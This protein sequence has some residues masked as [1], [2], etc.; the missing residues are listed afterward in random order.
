MSGLES[1]GDKNVESDLDLLGEYKE[2]VWQE[3]LQLRL[4]KSES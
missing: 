3:D 1:L 2:H 4:Q